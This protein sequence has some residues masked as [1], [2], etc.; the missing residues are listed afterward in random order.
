M[1][2]LGLGGLSDLASGDSR[3]I[4]ADFGTTKVGLLGCIIE[5]LRDCEGRVPTIMLRVVDIWSGL[6]SV[7][8]KGLVESPKGFE[9]KVGAKSGLDSVVKGPK[10]GLD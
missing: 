3:A 8:N 6:V 9:G 2:S 10:R 1:F 5:E 4:S 7:P